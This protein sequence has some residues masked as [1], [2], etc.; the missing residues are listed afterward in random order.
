M[1]NWLHDDVAEGDELELTQPAG[2]FCVARR[3]PRRSSRSA[4]A[5]G[6]PRDLDGQERAGHHRPAGAAA[7]RQ[8]RR[9]IGDLR[10]RARAPAARAPRSPRGRA[11]T[12]TPSGLRRRRPRRA[13]SSATSSTPTST[14]AVRGRSWT[15]SSD[16]LEV[17]VDARADL[18]RALR[19]RRAVTARGRPAARRRAGRDGRDGPR[20]GD[21]RPQGPAPTRS[22]YQRGRHLAGDGPARRP[23]AAVLVRGRQLRDVHGAA[24][25][26][27]R[28]RCGPTTRSTPD[29]VDEGWVLTC[30]ALPRARRS[31]SSTRSTLAMASAKARSNVPSGSDD[32]VGS[33]P[34]DLLR[35]ALGGAR[36]A[37]RRCPRR[38]PA[39]ASGSPGVSESAGRCPGPPAG[40]CADPVVTMVSRARTA[41]PRRCRRWSRAARRAPR[42]PATGRAPRRASA[43]R[44][45]SATIALT[46]GAGGEPRSLR[47]VAVGV[48]QL[49][50]PIAVASRANISSF[51]AGDRKP[52]A[53]ARTRSGC[54]GTTLTVSAPIALADEARTAGRRGAISSSTRNIDS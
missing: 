8:P 45:T 15:W 32:A 3:R 37:R 49:G 35:G 44:P 21:D 46:C 43:S 4:A 18:H 14:S 39:R 19:Q 54:A 51:D 6:S 25:R 50:P 5:A 40:R 7:V 23:A 17:G 47:A 10:R 42:P 13:S 27:A 31:P 1:S 34:G 9:A 38:A 30:Q 36:R 11:T 33:Q 24:R 20:D 22:K 26:R 12:S 16:A 28:P 29:E 41:G 48:G 53:V 52:A 2:V